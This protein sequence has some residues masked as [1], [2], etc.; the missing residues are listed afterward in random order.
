MKKIYLVLIFIGCT[1]IVN[2]QENR[3][4]WGV[5]AGISVSVL[6]DANSPI[7]DLNLADG[8]YTE[9]FH[10]FHLN[11]WLALQTGLA[12]S[13]LR[14]SNEELP[15]VNPP[16]VSDNYKLRFQYL[17]VP[18]TLQARSGHFFYDLGIVPIIH[19]GVDYVGPQFSIP[20][21]EKTLLEGNYDLKAMMGIG[22]Q[23]KD[24]EIS[25]R[26]IPGLAQ[27]FS[28][29]MVADQND[30]ML[31][32]KRNGRNLVFQLTVGYRIN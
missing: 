30:D 16:S 8:F 7:F 21:G 11:D 14:G 24:W 19:I 18:I 15:F 5:K 9:L 23:L 31:S 28:E 22:Y 27:A 29:I 6:D 4:Y 20:L 10:N 13:E 32:I 2:A 3:S 1:L 26:A 12:Y 17:T 25:L